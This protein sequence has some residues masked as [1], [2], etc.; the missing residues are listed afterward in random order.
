MDDITCEWQASATCVAV[1]FGWVSAMKQEQSCPH[2]SLS[3]QTFFLWISFSTSLDFVITAFSQSMYVFI[4]ILSFLFPCSLQSLGNFGTPLFFSFILSASPWAF[5][6]PSFFF[7][8]STALVF[9][10]PVFFFLLFFPHP[11][12]PFGVSFFLS[13]LPW[14]L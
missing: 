8:L 10:E 13:P 11:L 6:R 9:L 12:D 3:Y 4:S 14:S 5:W 7:S 2:W 1:Q